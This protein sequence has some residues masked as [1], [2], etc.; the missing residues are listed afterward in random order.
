MKPA[1]LWNWNGRVSRFAYFLTG[2]LA[3]LVKHSVDTVLAYHFG[4]RW[5][6]WNY[7]APVDRLPK[8]QASGD[9]LGH[10]LVLL[11]LTAIPFI[12]IGVVMT[13]NR[14]RDAGQPVWLVLLSFV[15]VVNLLLFAVLCTLPTQ[16]LVHFDSPG[17]SVVWGIQSRAGSAT[18]AALVAGFMGMSVTWIDL[19]T[20]GIYGLSLFVALPFVMGYLA[21]WLHCLSQPRSAADIVAVVSLSVLLAGLGIAAVAIEGIIC[22][23]MAAPIAW[24]LA[25]CGGALAHAVHNHSATQRPA[26]SSLAAL[27]MVLPAFFGAEH[28]A[29]PPV[30]RYQVHTGM[31]I[32]APPLVVWNRLIAFPPIGAPQELPFRLGISYPI[33]AQIQ[34]EGLTADRECR[35]SSGSFKEPILVW[36]P[37]KHFAFAVADEPMLMKE[38]SPYPDIKVRHLEDHDFQP[39]RADFVLTVLPNGGT[40]L[41]GTTT[42]R[43]KMWPGIYWRLWTD[44]IVH[45]IH[46]R[47]FAHVKQLAEADVRPLGLAAAS[48]PPP[49]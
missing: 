26:T 41:E 27:L 40:H 34:G 15:P 45:S 37:G 17:N 46:R 31:D 19:R 1:D 7:W 39:E 48:T 10:F 13:V 9:P 22:L 36:E 47:V 14:L 28:F 23:L 20:F 12:W 43:N 44:T 29:P 3:F 38:M 49:R 5:H 25:L 4:L 8:P 30:P 11:F 16:P 6:L 42:Y 33:E 2:L 21:V 24:I 18:L 35:F 32:A